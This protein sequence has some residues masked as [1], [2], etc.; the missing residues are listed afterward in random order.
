MLPLLLLPNLSLDAL[1]GIDPA[2]GQTGSHWLC[3]AL[4]APGTGNLFQLTVRITFLRSPG[5]DPWLQAR[6]PLDAGSK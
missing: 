5:I 1:L 2:I 6:I 3:S 4:D